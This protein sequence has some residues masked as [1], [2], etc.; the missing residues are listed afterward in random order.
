MDC[1]Q[2]WGANRAA[3][4]DFALAVS[5]CGNLVPC[6]FGIR[7]TNGLPRRLLHTCRL[8]FI[9]NSAVAISHSGPTGK[10]EVAH[11]SAPVLRKP[12][13]PNMQVEGCALYETAAQE[14]TASFQ[15]ASLRFDQTR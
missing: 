12:T 2:R 8:V 4:G 9:N 7:S 3:G 6:S 11:R 10:R 15:L 13:C 14:A 5:K 1:F